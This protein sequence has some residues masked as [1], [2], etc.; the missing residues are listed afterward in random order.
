MKLLFLC[1][2]II[3]LTVAM[4]LQALAQPGAVPDTL[5]CVT[6]KSEPIYYNGIPMVDVALTNNCSDDIT[7]IAV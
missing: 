1:V 2:E 3:S 7:A 4:M 6:V 5:A